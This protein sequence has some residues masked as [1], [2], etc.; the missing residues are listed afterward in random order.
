MGSTRRTAPLALVL[1][2]LGPQVTTAR[3]AD[4][5]PTIASATSVGPLGHAESV[6]N[7][8]DRQAAQDGVARPERD[9]EKELQQPDRSHLPQNPASQRVSQ[10]PEVAPD[11][12]ATPNDN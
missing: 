11:F 9:V 10:L 2:L 4:R 1:D 12:K 6:S 5:D 8:M 7:V 3:A